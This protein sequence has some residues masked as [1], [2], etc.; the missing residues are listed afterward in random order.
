M[1][2]VAA[3]KLRRAQQATLASHAYS[4]S[5]RTMVGEARALAGEDDI[6]F[7]MK[8]TPGKRVD[9]V[10]FTSDRGLC[11][12]FNENLIRRTLEWILELEREGKTITV[13]IIGRKGRDSLRRKK[14]H[15]TRL[16]V[17]DPL[18]EQNME[19][20]TTKI[21]DL[22]TSRFLSGAAD[23]TALAFNRFFSAGRQEGIIEELLPLGGNPID[24]VMPAD[25]I[26]EPTK[27]DVLDALA[28]EMILQ[29]VRQALYDSRAS[30][31]AARMRAMENATKN[32][33]EMIGDLTLV[34][35]RAR[36][37]TITRELMDIVG[38][39]EA[40]R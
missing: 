7:L 30:E 4:T 11:G 28:K 8:P 5:L 2:L 35:N 17:T 34:F 40:L 36:Q 14:M 10:L 23:R 38:G 1:K 19:E 32:A 39:A 16:E 9:C 3:A 12:G 15:A 20:L 6:P 21:G 29:S 27:K 37:A 18:P 31:Y 22:V 24:K 26:F 33:E 13:I 25:A